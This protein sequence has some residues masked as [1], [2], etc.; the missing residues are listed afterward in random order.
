MLLKCD[1]IYLSQSLTQCTTQQESRIK[2]TPFLG[3]EQVMAGLA[4]Y[5][6]LKYS[7]WIVS[8]DFLICYT[9]K[10]LLPS[11][12]CVLMLCSF[13][14]C[15]SWDSSSKLWG[16][17]R[18]REAKRTGHSGTESLNG[19]T[20]S[21][22]IALMTAQKSISNPHISPCSGVAQLPIAHSALRKRNAV[23]S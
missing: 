2:H 1:C 22:N 13:Y 15:Q 11:V 6:M 7:Q 3:N 9:A 4:K 17:Q 19:L 23:N 14:F 18:E 16:A 5:L 8:S 21:S 12:R 10:E 20:P